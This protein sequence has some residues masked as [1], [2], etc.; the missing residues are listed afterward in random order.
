MVANSHGYA[1]SGDGSGD[2]AFPG[3]SVDN[4]VLGWEGSS[5]AYSRL[6]G[7]SN[8]SS[9]TTADDSTSTHLKA[10]T[11]GTVTGVLAFTQVIEFDPAD[12]YYKVTISVQNTSGTALSDVRVMHNTDPDHNYDTFST[13]STYD[14]VADQAGSGGMMVVDSQGA[15]NHAHLTWISGDPL[16]R[17][18]T[19][20]FDNIDVF[21]SN[22]YESPVDSD[23]S[24]H[25]NGI[26]L[27][28]RFATI[29]AGDTVSTTYYT[30]INA[31]TV[32]NDFL[33]GTGIADILNAN[34]GNDRLYGLGGNDVLKGG[35]GND[36]LAGGA[37]TDSLTGGTGEDI[38]RFGFGHGATLADRLAD[39]GVDT[40][41]DFVHGVDKIDLVRETFGLSASD[42]VALVTATV[43]PGGTPTDLGATNNAVVVVGAS[44]GGVDL[45]FTTNAG[46]SDNS[47]SYQIAHLDS[48]STSDVT[49]ADIRLSDAIVV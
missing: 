18:S 26:N 49:S 47:N 37:G 11:T 22:Y 44:R 19:T 5:S 8:F 32:G 43:A 39:L 4:F 28:T 6:G 9:V 21:N 46:A 15:T 40:I 25:D 14:D 13:F 42:T 35:S 10:T 24:L 31:A 41:T 3:S 38:F 48:V 12:G 34:A 1:N 7:S 36:T 17:G 33:T 30:S 29:A 45:Y 27:V 2:Y 23:G 16:A 20:G